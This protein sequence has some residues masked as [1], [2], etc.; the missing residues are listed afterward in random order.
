VFGRIARI[1]SKNQPA[2]KVC[3]DAS[4]MR[5]VAAQIRATSLKIV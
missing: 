3:E 2:L 5:R 1:A 4:L